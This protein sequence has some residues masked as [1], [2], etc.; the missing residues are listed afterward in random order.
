MYTVDD[1]IADFRSDV[2][3]RADVDANGTPRDTLW[4]PEDVLRYLNEAAH[5]WAHDTEFLRLNLT[6]SVVSGKNRYYVGREVIDIIEATYGQD[7]TVRPTPLHY[8]NMDEG[9][10]W[11]DYGLLYSSSLDLENSTGTPR[12]ISLDYDPSYLRLYPTPVGTGVMRLRMVVYPPDLTSGMPLPSTSTRD[13]AL[14]LAWMKYLAYQ[15]QD[16]D[17]QD[18]ERSDSY[19]RQYANDMVERKYEL[20]RV[21]RDGG[22]MTSRW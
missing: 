7:T 11:D 13:R 5:Q 8:F 16:A 18:L 4:S 19:R 1:L 10:C 17:V 3:D 12:G 20:D 14:M 9:D 15:K 6:L 22:I 2:Y 21:R